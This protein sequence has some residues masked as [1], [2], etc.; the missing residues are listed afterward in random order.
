MT[1]QTVQNIGRLPALTPAYVAA[2]TPDTF[3]PGE[4]VFLHVK[5]GSG[6]SMNVVVPVAAPGPI[7]GLGY[8]QSISN[9]VPAGQE[10]MIGPFPAQYFAD[11]VTGL[12]TVTFSSTASV[13]YGVFQM[14]NP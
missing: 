3:L 6:A 11:P 5:N 9:A 7:A 8:V 12:A 13:T 4:D 1:L 14:V 2:T 10:R